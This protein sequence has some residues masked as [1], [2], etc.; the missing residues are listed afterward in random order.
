MADDL[1]GKAVVFVAFAVGRR[2][3]VGLPILRCEGV[4]RNHRRSD[5]VMEVVKVPSKPRQEAR[6]L[7]SKRCALCDACAQQLWYHALSPPYTFFPLN[8]DMELNRNR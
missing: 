7:W 5:Y 3:H 6:R 4:E 1:A 2:G 8:G